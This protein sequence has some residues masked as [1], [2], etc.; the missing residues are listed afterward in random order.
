MITNSVRCVC[1]SGLF[2]FTM[3]TT[4][5]GES[6]VGDF[7]YNGRLEAADIDALTGRV[8]SGDYDA[9]Y[10]V[11]DDHVLDGQDRRVWVNE[12]AFT[13]FGDSDLN[14]VFNTGD[15]IHVFQYGHYDDDLV[16]NSGWEHGD[17]N[18]DREFSSGDLVVAFQDGGFEGRPRL[19]APGTR[20]VPEP[21]S[22]IG[23]VMMSLMAIRRFY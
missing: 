17:W 20:A 8:L 15:L 21:T 7:D 5:N 2:V 12:L 22:L 1:A 4:A 13:Y 16:A 14:G 19:K 23:V 9:T 6:L 11:N 10:D 3:F 18:G